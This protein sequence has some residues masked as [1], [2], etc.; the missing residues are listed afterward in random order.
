MCTSCSIYK[1]KVSFINLECTPSHPG[2]DI[3]NAFIILI[4]S[5]SVTLFNK[6]ESGFCLAIYEAGSLLVCGVLLAKFDPMFT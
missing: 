5:F 4:T 1:E 3:F 2:R 6:I